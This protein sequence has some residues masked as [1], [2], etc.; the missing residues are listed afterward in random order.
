MSPRP[1]ELHARPAVAV[2]S[3]L[4]RVGH[5]K[6]RLAASVG[7]EAARELH[8]AFLRDELAQLRAPDRWH[9]HL[10]HDAPRDAAE[11]ALLNS[12]LSA[13]PG[14]KN[15]DF[16]TIGSVVPGA[17][18]LGAE[19]LGAFELLLSDHERAVI[20]SG[21]VPHIDPALVADALALL[22]DADVVLGP[23]PDGGYYLVGM[24]APH[25]I[26]TT[27]PM[28]TSAVA[29]ATIATARRMGLRTA[30]VAQLTDIDEVQDLLCLEAAPPHLAP[31]TRALVDGLQR[32]PEAVSL[33]TELQVEVT[34]R[35]NLR[36]PTCLRTDHPLEAEAD[37]TLVDFERITAGLPRLARVAF[38][39]N[40]ESTLCADLPAM[41]RH[42]V[43]RGAY[44]VLNTNGTLLDPARRAALLTSGLHELRVSLDGV[45]RDTVTLMAGADI[46]DRV[47]AGVRALMAERGAAELPRVSLW[48]VSTRRTIAEL[49]GLVELAGE[50][51]IEEVY[52]QRLVLTGTGEAVAAR[53]L[54]GAIDAE[55]ELHIAAAEA[56][57]TRLGIA[58]RASGRL[59]I[60]AS[61]ATADPSA[62]RRGCWRPWRSAVVTANQKVLPCCISSFRA[63]YDV[64]EMGDLRSQ[65][66]RE[67]YDGEA[68]RAVRR[69]ILAADPDSDLVHPGC[70]GCGELWSL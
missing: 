17:P 63:T 15:G 41:I 53:S 44:T 40:G 51:G 47:I 27:V 57:A 66:W 16:G 49:A 6:T 50:L 46:R 11:R 25:D 28:S 38:Q 68:Y 32:L 7:P 34:N 67:I 18:S 26:F 21:D 42:A 19:L 23:G 14:R 37:L 3:K 45:R 31:R 39:L 64:L 12:L 65:S 20:V 33:P 35:C 60:R 48:M 2:I 24:R 13:L 54:H 58:L 55:I 9:L 22:D 43:G 52:A 30:R 36:C 29:T 59:P 8:E 69:G 5:S 1:G 10:V 56:A 61:F 70:R 62:P 4:P